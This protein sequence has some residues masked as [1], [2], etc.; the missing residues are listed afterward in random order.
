MCSW[1]RN[2]DHWLAIGSLQ[3]HPT[4]NGLFT[5]KLLHSRSCVWL[6]TVW[7]KFYLFQGVFK[8]FWMSLWAS[9]RETSSVRSRV[10]Y[11]WPTLTWVVFWARWIEDVCWGRTPNIW[12]SGCRGWGGS[13]GA[14][15][16][17]RRS[18]SARLHRYSSRPGRALFQTWESPTYTH[19]M[20][21]QMSTKWTHES[22]PVRF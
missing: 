5:W 16:A 19:L 6:K 17:S 10:K 15:P 1:L 18:L 11:N 2:L 3:S 22:R 12:S 14:S 7:N 8:W 13:W 9:S 21:D 4:P 20:W